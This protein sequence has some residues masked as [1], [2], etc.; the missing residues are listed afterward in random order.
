M[1]EDT[2][3]LNVNVTAGAGVACWKDAALREHQEIVIQTQSGGADPVSIGVANPLPVGGA[4]ADLAAD[5]G[6]SIKVAGVYHTAPITVADGQRAPLQTDAAGYLKVN[7]AAGGA[8]GGTSSAIAAAVPGVA[9]AV[10]F[11]DGT[12]MRMGVVDGS[13]NIKV[14]IAA[15]GVPAGVDNNA[16]TAGSTQGLPLLGVADE[17]N[18]IGAITQGNQGVVKLTLDRKQWVAI[19]AAAN[20]GWTPHK[21]TSAASTNGTRLKASPGQIGYLY[22]TNTGAGFAYIKLYDNTN[23]PP[24]V[25][26]DVPVQVYGLPPG[27]GGNLPIPA[28]IVFTTGIG[29][30]ICGGTGADAD[31]NAVL[32]SQVNLNIG[33]K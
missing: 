16:F 7:V 23:N 20:G 15:G 33:Y 9:T 1:A 6:N 14:N 28:G 26:T 11:S 5:T 17:L 12:N 21:K 30:G 10:G 19:G 4:V 2:V 25:G 8:S 18:A 22:A 27:G 32:L 13:G 24:V 29:Y 3:T 31:V